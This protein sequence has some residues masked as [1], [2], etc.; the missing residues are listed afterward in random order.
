MLFLL[1]MMILAGVQAI[2]NL[3]PVSAAPNPPHVLHGVVE[4]LSGNPLGAGASI[5]A[6]INEV[7]FAQ[8]ITNPSTGV[9]NQNTLTHGLNSG[10][11][12]GVSTNFQ[13]CADDES[14]TFAKEGGATGDI[15][16]FV[17]NGKKANVQRSGSSSVQPYLAFFKAKDERVDLVVTDENANTEI[18]SNDACTSL[19]A[20]LAPTA[21]PPT[22]PFF[23]LPQPTATPAPAAAAAAMIPVVTADSLAEQDPTDAAE[24]VAGLEASEAAALFAELTAESAALIAEELE[25][26]NAATILEESDAATAAGILEVVDSEKAAAILEEVT[27]SKAAGIIEEVTTSK[28]ADI[29]EEVT[30]SKAAV[31]IEVVTTAKAAGIFQ[32]WCNSRGDR[33]LEGCRNNRESKCR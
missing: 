20:V 22:P 19:Q 4:D 7:N 5:Q 32:S 29:I 12:Y 14:T 6:R 11:N 16:F 8:V 3:A 25:P 24:T 28:A 18:G 21:V 9:G 31:I 10:L 30:T 13:V 27:T 15:I 33:N 2:H 1:G 17:V 26:G 23:I